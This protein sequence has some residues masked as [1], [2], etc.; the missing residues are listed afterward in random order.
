MLLGNEID[1]AC[2]AKSECIQNF[3]C[4]TKGCSYLGDFVVLRLVSCTGYTAVMN[5][6]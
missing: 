6:S 5:L 2:T 1:G 4:K 3:G